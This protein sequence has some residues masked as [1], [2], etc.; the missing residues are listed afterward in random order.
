MGSWQSD[1]LGR[2]FHERHSENDTLDQPFLA[3]LPLRSPRASSSPTK[4]KIGSL[5]V[6]VEK[7]G[8][9]NYLTKSHHACR[10]P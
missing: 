9:I 6:S 5:S 3:H 8:T 2:E 7:V 10:P 4:K 1:G